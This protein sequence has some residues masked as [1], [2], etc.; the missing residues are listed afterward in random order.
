MMQASD[1]SNT[2][3]TFG[4]DHVATDRSI[5]GSILRD[6]FCADRHSI[7]QPFENHC[8]HKDD[9]DCLPDGC[10]AIFIRK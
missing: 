7:Q 2:T 3:P 1:N 10:Q 6:G 8:E 4:D 5:P 9:Q